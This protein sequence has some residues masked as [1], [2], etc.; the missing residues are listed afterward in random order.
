MRKNPERLA[1]TVLSIAF[2]V[3][4]AL[5]ISIPLGTR[6][7]ITNADTAQSASVSL[8][9]GTIL[10][11]RSP[12][13]SPEAV[14]GTLAGLN[15]GAVIDSDPNSQAAIN[16]AAPNSTAELGSLQVYGGSRVKL[17]LLR[18]PRFEWSTKPHRIYIEMLR[19]R[20]RVSMAVNVDRPITITLRT[21]HAIVVLEQAGSYSIEVTDQLTEVVVRDGAATVIANSIAVTLVPNE[22]TEIWAGQAPNGPLTGERNLV[23]NGD[24]S[25]PLNPDWTSYKDRYDPNDVEGSIEKTIRNGR[26]VVLF[27]RPGKNWGRTGIRHRINRDVRD[28]QT[29]RLHMAV[30]L[31]Y[32]SVQVCGSL[33]SE[34]PLMVKLEFTDTAG[35][36]HEWVQGFYYLPDAGTSLP[37]RCITCPPPS[38]PHIRVQQNVWYLYDSPDLIA[39]FKGTGY[40]PAVISAISIYAE[41]H[42]FESM[43]SEI[44]LQAGD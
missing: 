10:L 38:G 19:G 14:I 40:T 23:I 44:E 34:C 36:A 32:Q 41:G 24:F 35:N 1:W 43:V 9:S 8:I 33:G 22:R 4:C 16:F 21:P 13:S 31:N 25:H 27:S 20:A 37:M 5:T 11:T 7:Y 42:S 28:Y 18:S 6:W 3:F 12:A 2:V 17:S 30:R 29:L 15:E 26:N 39:L